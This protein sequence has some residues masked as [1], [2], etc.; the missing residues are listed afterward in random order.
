MIPDGSSANRVD[1]S[2]EPAERETETA[3]RRGTMTDAG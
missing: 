2:G 1:L 3:Y